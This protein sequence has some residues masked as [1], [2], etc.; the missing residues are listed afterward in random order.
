MSSKYL[1]S[2]FSRKYVGFSHPNAFSRPSL[3]LYDAGHSLKFSSNFDRFHRNT[4][5]SNKYNQF[6]MLLN[7]YTH[8]STQTLS[9]TW[10]TL[11]LSGQ[12]TKHTNS[13]GMCNENSIKSIL[14]RLAH[15]SSRLA[16]GKTTVIW[17]QTYTHK[18]VRV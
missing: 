4:M 3:C 14:V 13:P 6:A 17:F 5:S 8:R 2:T 7:V 9:Y 11:R 12:G 15:P 1:D 16:F 18:D 10:E